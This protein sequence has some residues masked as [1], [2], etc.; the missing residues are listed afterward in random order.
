[1]TLEGNVND[2]GLLRPPQPEEQP[3]LGADALRVLRIQNEFVQGFKALANL[4]PAVTLFGSARLPQDHPYSV[5][6]YEVAHALAKEGLAIISGGGPGIMEA[7]NRGAKDGGAL[8]VACNIE[9]PFE[10]K[11]NPYQDI[12]LNFRYFFVRKVILVKYARAFVIFPGGFG[13]LDELF[14]ILTLIQTQ[15]VS[16]F[17]IVLYGKDY[18]QDL[19]AWLR[20]TVL[21]EGCISAEDFNLFTI[22]DSAH[23]AIEGVLEPL[24]KDGTLPM[25]PAAG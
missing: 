25:K 9:L 3:I 24:R 4:G 17:P 8:S 5:A 20:N 6:A 12:S 16:P 7:A 19:L 2:Q 13:T 21:A 18:W 11:P 22:V 15:K 14:E 1:M 10:K 23:D